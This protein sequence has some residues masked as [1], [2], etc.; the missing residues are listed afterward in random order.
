MHESLTRLSV[1]PPPFFAPFDL[2]R[3]PVGD[4]LEAGA[5]LK[6]DDAVAYQRGARREAVAELGHNRSA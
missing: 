3:L 5:L 1:P 4:G 6:G 2:S